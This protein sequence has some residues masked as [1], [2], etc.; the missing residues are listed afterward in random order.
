MG[1]QASKIW[2]KLTIGSRFY[3]LIHFLILLKND[4]V[5][6]KYLDHNTE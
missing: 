3:V 1:C 2:L 4:A 5:K 6:S